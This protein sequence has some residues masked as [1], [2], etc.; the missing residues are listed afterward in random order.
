M[1]KVGFFKQQKSGCFWYRIKQKMDALEM[2][3]I[4]TE[5][6]QIDKDLVIDEFQ[7]FQFYG[8]YIFSLENILKYL[9]ENNKKIIYDMDDPLNLIEPTNLNYHNV[10]QHIGSVAQILHYTD[11]ITVSTEKMAEYA[12]SLAPTTKI[13]IL[14]N[15]FNPKEWQYTSSPHSKVRIGFAGSATHVEDLLEVLPAITILQKTYD[16]DFVIMGFGHSDYRE[17]FKH[18]RFVATPELQTL[19]YELD[20]QLT[21]I[22]F[23]WG[24]NVDFELYPKLL[25][26]LALDIGICPLKD[27]PFNNHR[28]TSKAMEYTLAG[29]LAISSNVLPYTED[30]TSI[31]VKDGWEKTLEYYIVNSDQR[32]L[33]QLM[34]YQWLQDHRDIN[35]QLETLKSVYI[36]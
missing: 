14:P 25:T 28:S 10:K 31:L 9:K 16:I 29:A 22:R 35:H 13:T 34:H 21:H 20:K 4:P 2:A 1:K 3:G 26:E 17:W 30:P 15:T 27:T 5:E 19:L 7:S 32:R 6:I 23:E 18:C 33:E 12:R 11:E 8:G 24:P 36:V